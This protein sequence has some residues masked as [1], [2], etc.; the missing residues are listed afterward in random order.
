MQT[1]NINFAPKS[2]SRS[3]IAIL[4]FLILSLLG[5]IYFTQ[6]QN[7]TLQQLTQ[8]PTHKQTQTNKV[9]TAP[10][11]AAQLAEIRRW[12][13]I[14]HSLQFDWSGFFTSLETL[15]NNDIAL[16]ALAPIIA[17]Q[18]LSLQI[19]AKDLATASAYVQTMNAS[20]WFAHAV[21]TQYSLA[22]TPGTPLRVQI[23]AQLT[24]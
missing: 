14:A 19:E 10:I 15:H 1:I 18:H 17:E 12:Q 7:I 6:Q 2:F 9:A 23:E 16:L 24:P 21:I 11:N 8:K 4:A 22:P 3:G 20:P 5:L 13:S